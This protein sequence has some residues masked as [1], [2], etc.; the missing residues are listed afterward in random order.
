[1]MGPGWHQPQYSDATHASHV[2]WSAQDPVA[3]ASSGS[4]STTKARIGGELIFSLR[5]SLGAGGARGGWALRVLA[6]AYS[7]LGLSGQNGH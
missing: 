7:A 5:R 4:E 3:A 2:F 6:G 1:M